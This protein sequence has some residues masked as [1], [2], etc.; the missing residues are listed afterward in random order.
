MTAVLVGLVVVL[1]AALAGVGISRLVHRQQLRKDV[2]GSKAT[3][4]LFPFL[5]QALSVRALDAALRLARAE[6]ATLVPVFLARVSMH[7]PLDAPLPRQSAVA[8]SMQE[9]IEQRAAVFDVAVDARIDRGR[10]YRHALRQTLANERF[11]RVVIA[12]ATDGGAGFGAE[13]IAW[14]LQHSSGEILVLRPSKD[15]QPAP[16]ALRDQDSAPVAGEYRVG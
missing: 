8:S 11:D 16:L 9:A 4:I 14:L 13:D 6:N 7:L 15:E 12:A 1:G 2:V 10:T 5:A 3:R